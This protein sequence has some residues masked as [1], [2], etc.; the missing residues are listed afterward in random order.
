[1]VARTEARAGFNPDTR[2]A[3]LETDADDMECDMRSLKGSISKLT[4]AVVGA[5]LT[6][7]T[8]AV[9]LAINLAAMA[10]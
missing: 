4:Y 7:G 6:M 1:M 10:G 2:I 8:T 3:L 5:A 9:M